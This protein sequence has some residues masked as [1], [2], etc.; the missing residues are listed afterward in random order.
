MKT[1][2]LSTFSHRRWLLFVGLS[3][4]GSPGYAQGDW[5]SVANLGGNI[6][7]VRATTTDEAGNVYLAGAFSGTVTLGSQ[8]LTSVGGTDVFLAKWNTSGFV[9]AQR[10]G[11]VGDDAA[12]AV[13]TH[14]GSVYVGGT[15]AGATAAFGSTTLTNAG[16]APT[17][18]IFVARYTDAGSAANLNWAQQAGGTAN[19]ELNAVAATAADVYAVGSFVGSA[20]FGNAFLTSSVSTS[21][22]IFI[23][24]LTTTGSAGGF[25]WTQ[26]AG[27]PGP[28][29]ATAV[30]VSG[31]NVYVAG[32]FSNTG[33]FG[34][35][36][37]FSAGNQDLFVTRLT[38]A[39]STSSFAWVQRAGGA[40]DD[41]ATCLA[42]RGSGVYVAGSFASIAANFTGV[43][44]ANNGNA[45]LFVAKLNDIGTTAP[46][47]SWAQRAGGTGFEQATAL[48]LNGSSLYVAGQFNSPLVGFGTAAALS[49]SQS[50]FF[51]ILVA[52]INDLGPSNNFTWAQQAG[53]PQHDYAKGLAVSGA[54]VYMVGS[55]TLPARFGSQQLSGTA[56][57]TTSFLATLLDTNVITAQAEAAE[58]AGLS[59][60]PNPAHHRVMLQLP[61][62]SGAAA[63][64]TLL[65]ATGRIVRSSL[66]TPTAN[67]VVE[68]PLT[69]LRAGLYYVQVQ[70][71][72]LRAARPLVV[73]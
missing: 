9:W 19:D 53:S 48:A 59:L 68:V 7:D 14:S 25:V 46:V 65:D 34:T 56:G 47:F 23:T 71:G 16:T 32:S 37:V 72:K 1:S 24:K 36:L 58:L 61:A 20:R 57:T 2:F 3:L 54:R 6:S 26:S 30:G 66:V 51:D 8:T 45:D 15:F 33:S 13:A 43:I 67:G 39:G 73:E 12:T 69:G 18:D 63:T 10:A 4:A 60:Y 42:V 38:D 35:N 5:Q 22:D 44:L 27:G 11:G 31:A 55:V 17:T 29:A 21:P 49:N 50:G 28:D 41:L 62:G 70:L 52:K 40:N 64:A